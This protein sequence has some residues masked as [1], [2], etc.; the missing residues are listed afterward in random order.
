MLA[1]HDRRHQGD[2]PRTPR[3]VSRS[4]S[5]VASVSCSQTS[6]PLV[7]PLFSSLLSCPPNAPFSLLLTRNPLRS[8]SVAEDFGF[9]HIFWV[10]SGRRGVHCWVCDKSARALAN[11]ARTAIV[12]YFS[13]ISGSFE[14][15]RKNLVSLSSPIHPALFRAYTEL[16]AMFV[17]TMLPD[18]GQGYLGNRNPDRWERILAFIPEI[19]GEGLA[20]S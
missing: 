2:G 6:V 3:S 20:R 13:A 4:R 19:A 17:E 18:E 16:E 1:V 11:D 8:G 12:E 14:T 15:N 10:Y 7:S 5:P 9:R